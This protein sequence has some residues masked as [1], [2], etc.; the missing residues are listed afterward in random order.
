[1]FF[2]NITKLPRWKLIAVFFITK[3]ASWKLFATNKKITKLPGWKL[4][5]KY[6]LQRRGER[7][8]PK[9]KLYTIGRYENINA[10]RC[11][12]FS[13]VS[14]V[15]IP[16]KIVFINYK[17]KYQMFLL[18]IWLRFTC[19]LSPLFLR[20][21]GKMRSDLRTTWFQC[22][23]IFSSWYFCSFQRIFGLLDLSNKYMHSEFKG[24]FNLFNL[25]LMV[26]H[27]EVETFG[28][29]FSLLSKSQG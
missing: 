6:L 24:E 19:T 2:L 21:E 23:P 28:I 8:L 5:N 11:L 18:H 17:Q 25:A 16:K 12:S 3:L 9:D 4:F 20:W 1:M 22:W 10:D 29:L 26:V 14:Y 7:I 13:P 15:F 27:V